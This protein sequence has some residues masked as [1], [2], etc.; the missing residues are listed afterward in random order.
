MLLCL[1]VRLLE[2]RIFLLSSIGLDIYWMRFIPTQ[3]LWAIPN[4]RHLCFWCSIKINVY[5][6]SEQ[7]SLCTI[8]IALQVHRCVSSWNDDDFFSVYVSLW[9]LVRN[10]CDHT[11]SMLATNKPEAG[12]EVVGGGLVRRCRIYS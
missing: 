2:F 10:T 1:A 4:P 8:H 7:M 9:F 12:I 3:P 6:S 5:I 11:A